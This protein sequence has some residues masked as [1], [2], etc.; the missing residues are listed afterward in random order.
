MHEEHYSAGRLLTR[1]AGWGLFALLCFWVG[2]FFGAVMGL[3]AG[4][5]AFA[6]I[7]KVLGD[8]VAVRFGQDQ[9]ELRGL[10][11][12]VSMRWDD[13]E[14]VTVAPLRSHLLGFLP[15]LRSAQLTLI[16]AKTREPLATGVPVALLDL[17]RE[18]LVRLVKVMIFARSDGYDLINPKTGALWSDTGVVPPSVAPQAAAGFGRKGL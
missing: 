2:G 16:D 11:K 5:F 8:R 13:V 18:G 12:N 7:A 15:T 3:V 4:L 10:G 14:D 1:A 9:V 17:D 6:Y